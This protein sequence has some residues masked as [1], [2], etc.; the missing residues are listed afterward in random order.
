[1][2]SKI[3]NALKPLKKID[4]KGEFCHFPGVTVVAKPSD[5]ALSAI[6]TIYELLAKAD[7]IKKYFSLLPID[8]MHMTFN[9]LYTEHEI[10]SDKWRAFLGGK[11]QLFASLIKLY[12]TMPES[13]SATPRFVTRAGALF[14][15]VSLPKEVISLNESIAKSLELTE[16]MPSFF[17]ITLG[18]QFTSL[19][20]WDHAATLDK[21]LESIDAKL[22]DIE[23][24]SFNQPRLCYFEDMTAFHEWDGESFPFE[25]DSASPSM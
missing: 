13:I 25:A 17:H 15:E 18:Y 12:D 23:S 19:D 1:M 24:L 14:L 6:N 7:P 3:K 4:Q 11:Q 5:A 10:G 9:N 2:F 16:K 21:L 20:D 8:S 22:K